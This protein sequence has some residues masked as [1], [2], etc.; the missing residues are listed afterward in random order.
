MEEQLYKDLYHTIFNAA[1]DAIRALDR[2]E[3]ANA[4]AILIRAQQEAEE[5]YL[6][7]PEQEKSDGSP[8]DPSL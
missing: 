2:G 5:R 4:A 3:A 1:T 6:S 7:R 8:A